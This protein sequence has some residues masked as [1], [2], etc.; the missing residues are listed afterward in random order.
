MEPEQ[1]DTTAAAHAAATAAARRR[2]V[3]R[4]DRDELIDPSD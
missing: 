3:G 1:P 4:R 2:L